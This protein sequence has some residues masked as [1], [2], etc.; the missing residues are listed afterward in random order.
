M[1]GFT[2]ADLETVERA[3]ATGEL[4]VEYPGGMRV[5][6]RDMNE[7]RQA[8]DMIKGE[9]EEAGA[10]PSTARRSFAAFSRD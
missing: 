3:I 7:L 6:Y 8:R 10:L 4:T 5:T 9:L 2:T 1:A